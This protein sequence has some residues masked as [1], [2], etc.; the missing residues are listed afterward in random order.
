MQN[1]PGYAARMF[2]TLIKRIFHND[3]FWVDRALKLKLMNPELNKWMGGR[4]A[5]K[6]L[7]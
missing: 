7:N 1:S 3:R 5:D 6:P 2:R 4:M